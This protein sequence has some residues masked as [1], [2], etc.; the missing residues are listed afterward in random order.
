MVIQS[1]QDSMGNTLTISVYDFL[2]TERK[3]SNTL[4]TELLRF[5]GKEV[6]Q[7]RFDNLSIMKLLPD[8]VILERAEQIVVSR[9]QVR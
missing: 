6:V 2:P 9:R 7:P 4:R 5:G 8:K 1:E 3:W